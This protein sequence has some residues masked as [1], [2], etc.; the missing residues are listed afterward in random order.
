MKIAAG[1][2]LLVPYGRAYYGEALKAVKLAS[3]GTAPIALAPLQA[4]ARG[5]PQKKTLT[6]EERRRKKGKLA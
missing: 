2:E 5:R 6:R 4:R 1:A 3:V